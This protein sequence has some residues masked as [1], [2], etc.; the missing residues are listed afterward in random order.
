MKQLRLFL[1]VLIAH[2]SIVNSQSID[3]YFSTVKYRN[4]GPF[5]GGRANAGT[6]VINDPLIYYMGTTGGGVWK[7]ADGGQHWMNI[8]D[9]FFKTASVGAIAVSAS[10][11]SVV[12]VG[13]GEHAPRGVMTSHGDGVYKSVDG[14]KTWKHMGL[15]K[16]QHIAR[17]IIHP[18]NPDIL[19]VAAQGA[20]HGPSQER[21]VFKS[22]DGGKTWKKTLYVNSLTGASEISIDLNNPNVL[23]AAMW[24]HQRKPWQV[25]SGGSG[26]GLYKSTD[27]GLTWETIHDGLPEEKGK[28]A[29]AV[30]QVNSELVYALIESDSNLEKGG[31][32]V[33]RNGG[34]NWSKVSGDH[35]LIQRAWYYIE[36]ALDPNNEN[37]LY[38]LSASTYKSIDAGKSWEEV[39][40][41]HGD[42]HDLW[43]NPNDSKNMI[44]TSD[45]GCEI[46]FNSGAHWSR[47][48]HLPTAQFYRVTTDNLFPYNV[49]GGQQ[50]NSS[51]KIA[52]IGIGSRTIGKRHWSPSAGGESAFLA[53]DPDQPDKVM[54]GSYLGTIEI[55]DVK[56]QTSNNI[57]IEPNL[58]LG[59]AARDM[60]YLYN[61]NAPIVRSMHEANTYY[62]GAQ[63][64]LR[65]RDEGQSWEVISPDLTTNND[66][67]QGKGGGPLTNEAVGAENYGTL[68][69]VAESPHEPGVIYT[70]S[71]DGLVY[72]TKNNGASWENITP[73][74]LDETLINSIEISPTNPGT[75][76]IATTRYKFN[77]FK[78]GLFKSTNYGK[79]W[80]AINNG[81]DDGAYTRVLREDSEN[82]N[83]LFAGTF[84]G[85]YCSWD[86]GEQW[87]SLQLNL[88]ITPITDLAVSHND[89]IVATQGR[90]FWILDDLELIRQFNASNTKAKVYKPAAAMWANWSSALNSNN[91][92]SSVK[93]E[94]DNPA[95]GLVIYYDLPKMDPTETLTMTITNANGELI[96]RF[97]SK[98]D[99]TF[100]SYEGGPSKPRVLTKNKGLNRFVWN[101]RHADLPGIS[102][103]YIE[104][105]YKGHKAIP[106]L[107]QIAINYGSV[108]L[109]T[110]AKIEPHP[111]SQLQLADY[112]NY[113][114]F[115]EKAE[116][117]YI[118]MTQK[119]NAL[120]LQL[121]Q[122]EA[123]EPLLK[124]KNL[125][126]L[127]ERSNALIKALNKWDSKMAQRL[128][129]A[130]DDVENYENGFT[131]HYL[132][133]INQVDASNPKVTQGALSRIEELDLE[134][135]LLDS[136]RKQLVEEITV[137]NR[138]CF[139][140]GIGVIYSF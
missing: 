54:G 140:K 2:A 38:V 26:S 80:Q 66:Q 61:W 106:G 76:Y 32:F 116:R 20:L 110:T 64:L 7:T 4:I 14:G 128:A 88:P 98:A 126:T 57:M 74:Q 109:E 107:Y 63:Y 75:V 35:R 120:K 94:G 102:K 31:L 46:T 105:S 117:N 78:P 47:I 136:E 135:D 33:S 134:W 58:Y 131:A 77:D 71:D 51:V 85:V 67:K 83:L 25:I 112:R 17:I 124:E 44:L 100:V 40:S 8:S 101:L 16:T 89:L 108:S 103:V 139:E 50:D 12:Y 18:D 49:Y 53:F 132:T 15:E 55:L 11:S 130:Y 114:N 29:I 96:N 48:D 138:L 68:S 3:A 42:Y 39:D 5:R 121:G 123:L 1:I 56:S 27:S 19:W 62:H 91:P 36:L 9:G 115:M 52:S 90:S 137:F 99:S 43:I 87:Q 125:K 6:G 92:S 65:S 97:S 23:Y 113:H 72:V 34:A 127:Q 118:E 82:P 93:F 95:T 129:K 28:M 84:N 133:A 41:A 70:G 45:G 21:G 111:M 13:M 60:K 122:I 24:E 69:Y 37:T 30:S 104:G 22:I 10:H 81:I 73:K 119:T 79:T 86:G 59:L